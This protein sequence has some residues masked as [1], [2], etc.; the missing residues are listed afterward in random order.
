MKKGRGCK[1]AVFNDALRRCGGCGKIR[2]AAY[3]KLP[4]LMMPYGD[5]V[6]V[7]KSKGAAYA[8]L[9]LLLMPYGLVVFWGKSQWLPMAICRFLCCPPG[10]V[11]AC[12]TDI[13]VG[14]S[15]LMF[16]MWLS[17]RF[18]GLAAARSLWEYVVDGIC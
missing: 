16:C 1:I 17:V 5:A 13:S 14:V 6:L 3:T 8:K 2:R 18:V 10:I 11:G 15:L 12:L 4:V 9:P 7:G